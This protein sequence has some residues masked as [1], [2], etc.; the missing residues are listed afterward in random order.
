MAGEGGI[1]G[2]PF[3]IMFQF[4]GGD[5]AILPQGIGFTAYVDGSYEYVKSELR[6]AYSKLQQEWVKGRSVI[7]IFR[8]LDAASTE[9]NSKSSVFMDGVKLAALPPGR[10]TVVNLDPATHHTFHVGS[11]EIDLYLEGGKKYYISVDHAQQTI[12][13]VSPEVAGVRLSS[14]RAIDR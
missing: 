7:Y 8:D 13:L 5:E 3:A 11:S 12:S 4:F 2:I 1:F 9:R 6:E 14:P 10:Y